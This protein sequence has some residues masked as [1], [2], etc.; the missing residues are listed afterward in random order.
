MKKEVNYSKYSQEE[1]IKFLLEKEKE[2]DK[3][4]AKFYELQKKYDALLKEKLI[5]EEKNKLS[6][7]RLFG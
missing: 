6:A 1:L 4:E 5:L 7:R 3:L 2:Y